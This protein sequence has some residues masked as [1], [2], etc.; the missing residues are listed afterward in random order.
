LT[1][2]VFWEVFKETGDPICY[3]LYRASENLGRASSRE[4]AAASAPGAELLEQTAGS[5]CTD[6]PG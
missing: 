6:A 1:G 2:K 4:Q 5:N 3:L